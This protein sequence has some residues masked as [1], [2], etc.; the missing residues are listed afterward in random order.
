MESMLGL[1]SENRVTIY[2]LVCIRHIEPEKLQML[3][4]AFLTLEGGKKDRS[5]SICSPVHPP[6]TSHKQ[7]Q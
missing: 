1:Q 3:S 5:T 4:S 7:P 6:S 2:D